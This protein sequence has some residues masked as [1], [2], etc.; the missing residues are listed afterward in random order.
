V[1]K[2][3][4]KGECSRWQIT[5]IVWRQH[6]KQPFASSHAEA[7]RIAN[8]HLL[9]LRK[10]VRVDD[11]SHLAAAWHYGL[12]RQ[13]RIDDYAG[14]VLSLYGSVNVMAASQVAP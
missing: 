9:W 6:S 14:R 2:K 4:P 1:D 10:H 5:P 3:G 11:V 8:A 13:D 7:E 12:T